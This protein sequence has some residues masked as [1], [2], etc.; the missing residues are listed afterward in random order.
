MHTSAN[1]KPVD[2]IKNVDEKTYLE[3]LDNIKKALNR[4]QIDFTILKKMIMC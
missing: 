1:K 3:V 4:K 2:L